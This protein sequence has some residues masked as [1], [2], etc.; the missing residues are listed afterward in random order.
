MVSEKNPLFAYLG[1]KQAGRFGDFSQGL[2][3]SFTAGNLGERAGNAA[4]ATVGAAGV[5]GATAGA[6]ALYGAVT[7]ARDFRSMLAENPD[8]AAKHEEDPRVVNRM[9]STLR[10]FNPAFTQDPI[11]AGTYMRHMLEN[12]QTA[13]THAVEALGHRD[14]TK[15]PLGDMA[16]RASMAGWQP[17]KD[18]KPGP[19][20]GGLPP[21]D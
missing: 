11:V 17:K 8:V 13:G 16:L 15:S 14:K 10:T 21:E 6:K 2:G 7:K 20:Q 9:F 19:A 3:R 4:M 12:P 5:A 1:E 18:G